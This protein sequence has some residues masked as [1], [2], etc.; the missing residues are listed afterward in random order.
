MSTAFVLSGGGSL[1]SVQVGML[2]ALAEQGIT[3]DLVVGTSVGAINAAWIA[4]RPGV[5]GAPALADVWSSVHR[6]DV[7]PA[8]PL[9]GLLGFLGRRDHLVPA[10][11]LRALLRRHLTYERL[12]DAPIPVRVIAT[13]V[14]TGLEVVLDHGNAVD[15]VTASSALPGVFRPVHVGGQDLIDGGIVNNT[16]ISHAVEAG[17]DRIYV[18]PTGYACALPDGPHSALGVTL[19]ALTLLLQQRLI[20]DV[21]RYQHTV[22]IRVAPPLCPLTVSPTDFSHTTELI[23]RSATTTRHWLESRDHAPDQTRTLRPHRHDT[24]DLPA[25]AR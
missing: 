21:A 6:G 20:A 17:A 25:A 5:D 8:R 7:F 11:A 15:A 16:P 13:E 19:H 23:E 3:P 9:T 18:L 24:A 1:G 4:G 10:S 12:E 2:L 14:M 22:D